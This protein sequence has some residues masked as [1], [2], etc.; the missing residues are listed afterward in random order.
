MTQT[1]RFFA[2]LSAIASALAFIYVLWLIN[3]DTVPKILSDFLYRNIGERPYARPL[4]SALQQK[5]QPEA[6]CPPSNADWRKAQTIE[7]IHIAASPLCAP[8]NPYEIAAV[9]KGTN[10][11]SMTMSARWA[12]PTESTSLTI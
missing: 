9:V 7:G 2:L 3:P 12:A 10:N 8:D 11:I 1:G 6:I 5:L 4:K